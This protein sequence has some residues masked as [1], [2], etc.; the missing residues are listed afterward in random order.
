MRQDTSGFADE[1]TSRQL[2]TSGY[3]RLHQDIHQ[4]ASGYIEIQVRTLR[5]TNAS[6]VPLAIL[7]LRAS[8]APSASYAQLCARA[9]L[10][11]AD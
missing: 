2:N 3:I 10:D 1:D 11:L 9:P 8:L 6:L 4:D 7:L 5:P